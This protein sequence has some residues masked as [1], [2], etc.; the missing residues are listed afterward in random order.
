MRKLLAAL[1]IST[2]AVPALANDTTANM[3]AGGLIFVRSDAIEMQSEDLFISMDLVRVDYRFRNTS[4]EDVESIVAFPM[5]DISPTPYGNVSIPDMASDNFLDF[6][7]TADGRAIEPELEQRAFS[8]AG[9]DV[10]E[11]VKAK[12]VALFPYA[13][14]SDAAI[15]KMSEAERE[16]WITRGLIVIDTYDD[17]SGMKDHY[18]PIWTLKS[19]YWWRMSFPQGKPIAVSHSYKPSVGG[20]VGLTFVEDGK[21]GGARLDEYR[22]TYCV[23]QSFERAVQKAVDK[24][25]DNATP[26]YE[27]WISYIL[28]TG[29]NWRSNIGTFTLTIDKGDTGSLLSF[30]G[31]GVKKIG[32][33][34]FR[35][36][37]T[38]FYPERDLDI[39]ILKK[40]GAQ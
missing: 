2:L 5:P 35:M 23:D 18:V 4:D 30:C 16:D 28:T 24:A 31:D 3:G 27:Q 22:R 17:G 19:T 38:Q 36:T 39:L 26:Y 34:T 32:P 21:V 37:K 6:T 9:I 12:G 7:V 15:G 1:L 29:G 40:P 20:T 8:T 10:S 14:E 11:E 13:E 33:T 25:G